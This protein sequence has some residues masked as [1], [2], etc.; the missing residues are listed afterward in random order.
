MAGQT[1]LLQVY[2]LLSYKNEIKIL[3]SG[4]CRNTYFESKRS[5]KNDE[6]NKLNKVRIKRV[7]IGYKFYDSSRLFIPWGSNGP[8]KSIKMDSLAFLI[9]SREEWISSK[10]DLLHVSMAMSRMI[11]NMLGNSGRFGFNVSFVDRASMF[12]ESVFETSLSFTYV[13]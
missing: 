3:Y 4:G 9:E 11:K 10:W 6:Q 8:A 2:M 7:Y 13:L 1:T 12:V 5:C